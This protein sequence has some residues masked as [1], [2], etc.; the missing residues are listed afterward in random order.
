MANEK[1]AIFDGETSPGIISKKL[2]NLYS[3]YES[4]GMSK[5]EISKLLDKEMQ[6]IYEKM[7][8]EL[9]DLDKKENESNKN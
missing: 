2:S 8:R 9:H 7:M 3:K 6:T 4:Q 1:Y 5:E